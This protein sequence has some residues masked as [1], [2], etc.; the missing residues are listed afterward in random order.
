MLIDMQI[1]V[2]FAGEYS[3]TQIRIST[4]TMGPYATE[5]C[6]RH[7]RTCCDTL[8]VT[9]HKHSL[10]AACSGG[11]GSMPFVFAP[12]KTEAV[13]SH[14]LFC[15]PS[16]VMHYSLEPDNF[17]INFRTCR[18]FIGFPVRGISPYTLRHIPVQHLYPVT[19]VSLP[20]V[21]CI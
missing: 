9:F 4:W 17:T 14:S 6:W 18:Y 21:T 7:E 19:R 13:P 20:A 12:T 1:C 10:P 15:F 2:H 11:R 8:Q 16:C 3:L 5:N